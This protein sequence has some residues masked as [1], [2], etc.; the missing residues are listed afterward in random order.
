MLILYNYI[1]TFQSLFKVKLAYYLF[2]VSQNLEH[3]HD[4]WDS[5][6]WF[7]HFDFHAEYNARWSLERVA[8]K[9]SISRFSKHPWRVDIPI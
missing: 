4:E 3:Q 5:T 9:D 6:I 1:W 2:S 8:I 7:S